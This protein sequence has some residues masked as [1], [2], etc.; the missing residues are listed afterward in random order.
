[1]PKRKTRKT[2][3]NTNVNNIHVNIH[4]KKKKSKANKTKSVQPLPNII[5]LSLQ[6]PPSIPHYLNNNPIIPHE[7]PVR[8]MPRAVFQESTPLNTV[9]FEP[10]RPIPVEMNT[11]TDLAGYSVDSMERAAMKFA[12]IERKR[13]MENLKRRERRKAEKVA[14][15]SFEYK[16]A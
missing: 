9:G 3:V 2:N 1:M 15:D 13:E 10:V 4:S 12:D 14:M 16:S 7:P 11:Q 6:Q 8:N 5:N